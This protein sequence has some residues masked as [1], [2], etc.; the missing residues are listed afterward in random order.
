MYSSV[1]PPKCSCPFRFTKQ[2][3]EPIGSFRLPYPC[4][5]LGVQPRSLGKYVVPKWFFAHNVTPNNVCALISARFI[6]YFA[7]VTHVGKYAVPAFV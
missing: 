7:S 4:S 5:G 3:Y 2:L 1:L 6:R